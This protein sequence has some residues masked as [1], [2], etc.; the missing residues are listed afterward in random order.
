MPNGASTGDVIGCGKNLE[1]VSS[2]LLD[3]VVE[4]EDEVDEEP[5]N[6]ES[7]E[8]KESKRKT[9]DMASCDLSETKG[10]H[11][12]TSVVDSMAENDQSLVQSEVTVE[13]VALTQVLVE[14]GK[15]D[16]G[17]ASEVSRPVEGPALPLKLGVVKFV[18]RPVGM[19][20]Y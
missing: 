6:E 19:V 20:L 3:T 2:S 8:L 7:T 4:R 12:T 14:S 13:M 9:S 16:S 18:S 11:V 5:A 10:T 15:E 17:D 1:H